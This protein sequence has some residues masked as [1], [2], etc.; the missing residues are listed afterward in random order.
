MKWTHHVQ[1][2]GQAGTDLD[3]TARV[4][5]LLL[6]A[7]VTTFLTARIVVHLIAEQYIP[8]L[9]LFV[10]G[11]HVH[12]LNYGILL[13]SWVGL[14]LLLLRPKGVGLYLATMVYG[15]GLALT[16]DEFGMWLSLGGSY[17][18][19]LTFDAIVIIASLLLLIVLALMVEER[20]PRHWV[21][22]A[23]VAAL[24]LTLA[25][26]VVLAF[27]HELMARVFSIRGL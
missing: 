17:N 19:H 15:I 11:T 7:F 16:F 21:I 9:F 26:L 22:V 23:V 10:K 8:N 20:H 27:R 14:I 3:I 25:G 18:N 1:K 12:H 24:V 13:L 5:R 4:A 2:F 6:L